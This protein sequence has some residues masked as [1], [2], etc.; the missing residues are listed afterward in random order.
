MAQLRRVP[1]GGTSEAPVTAE[2]VRRLLGFVRPYRRRMLLAGLFFTLSSLVFLGLPWGVRHI[3]DSVLVRRDPTLL[4]V[5]TG[6][7]VLL[8]VVQAVFGYFQTYL[9]SYV[10][11]RVVADIRA[12]LFGHMARL[13][14]SYFNERK[15]GELMSRVTS[16][17]TL[18]QT[19]VTNNLLSVFSQAVVL[20][21][22]VVIMLL[23]DWRLSLVI[24]AV[25]PPIA[26]FGRFFGGRLRSISRQTQEALGEANAILEET[27]SGVR[28]VKAFG[29]ESYEAERYGG[30]IEKAFHI[31]L[32]R[33]S[34]RAVF[35]PTI[36]LLGFAAVTVVLWYGGRQVLSGRLT[37]G[38]LISMLVYMLLI[39]A[40]IGSLT[41]VYSQL[42]EALGAA[43]RIFEVLDTEPEVLERPGALSLP[44]VR[45]SVELRNVSF[46]YAGGRT[47]L[48]DVSLRAE[49]GEVVALVGRSGAGNTTLVNLI[50]R[51]YEPQAGEIL[52]DGYHVENLSLE[53]LRSHISLVPQE[54]VLFGASARENI[55]YGRLDTSPEAI[56]AAARA[57]NAHEFI[58]RLPDGYDT[59]VGERGVKLSAGQR[60]RIAIARALLRNSKVL[61]LDEATAALD[62]ESEALVQ[63]ALGRLMR[64]RTTLVIA[65]R[66]STVERADRIVVLDA[67]RVIEQGTHDEL[68]GR[69]GL[70]YRLYT[71]SFFSAAPT[72]Q[73][74]PTL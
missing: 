13:P 58:M 20:V 3:V 50:P 28:V 5:V 25:L 49:P 59:L 29:R 72:G 36:T 2:G 71:R 16:D 70:Y 32:R 43:E 40:P 56:E 26:L 4:D 64:N 73:P 15:T 55:A 44:R 17:A 48:H 41:T 62:N 11:E 46:A 69:E 14:L 39:I 52:L 51:F 18:I 74:L 21:G 19:S 33:A 34:L 68:L 31:A 60:Q 35:V 7:L 65:H 6:A 42:A 10:G 30:N 9:L 47:V 38:E 24:V 61:I 12:A 8:L 63:E 45:G 66:L 37:P 1:R 27:L 23:T 67:G 53:T 57:A 54:T 22:G